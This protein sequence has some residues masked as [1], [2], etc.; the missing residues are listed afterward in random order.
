MI[1]YSLRR[2]ARLLALLTCLTL[3][4]FEH[5]GPAA[6]FITLVIAAELAEES[7]REGVLAAGDRARQGRQGGSQ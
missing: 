7:V 4:A 5:P 1:R 6:I 2:P 3:L